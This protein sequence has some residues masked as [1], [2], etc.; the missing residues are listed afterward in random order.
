[1]EGGQRE[2]NR[3]VENGGEERRR[4]GGMAEL[5]VKG[6]LEEGKE[7]GRTETERN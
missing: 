7:G 3:R 1:M 4:W 5:N 2:V 6:K